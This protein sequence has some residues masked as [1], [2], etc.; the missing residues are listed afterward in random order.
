[1]QTI[2]LQVLRAIA[3]TTAEITEDKF[4]RGSLRTQDQPNKRISEVLVYYGIRQPLKPIDED[5]N[6]RSSLLT[7]DLEAAEE[8]NGIVNKTIKSRWIPFGG[9]QVAERLSNIL[10]GRFRDPPRKIQFDTWRF[11]ENVPTLGQGYQLGW[12]ENQDETG[13]PALAPIQI[14]RVQPQPE[15]FSYEAEEVL[16]TFRDG[17]GDLNDRVIVIPANINDVNL[18]TM[19]DSIFPE[20][21]DDDVS[22]SP[23]VTLTCIINDNVIVGS[24]N[25]AIPAFDVGDWPVGFTPTIVINGRIQGRGGRGGNGNPTFDG[26]INSDGQPGGPAL[27]TRNNIDVEYGA[28]AEV[29]SGAGGGGASDTWV[30]YSAYPAPGG[31]GGAGQL[32]GQGGDGNNGGT[33]GTNGTTEAG[34]PG[35]LNIVET[36]DGDVHVQAGAG[37]G[38]GLPGED[39][40]NLFGGEFGPPLPAG[41]A[42][43]AAIDGVSFVNVTSGSGDIRGGQIN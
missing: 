20:I 28:N 1:V 42:A 11:A 35:G 24:T 21:T 8:Y 3:T 41:G 17:A 26:S 37:G 43:G 7:P 34:G 23:A 33:P 18:R 36:D 5:D 9:Q 19:H 14:T 6:Y 13:L 40:W 2:R 4:L 30:F 39:G 38:P 25:T 12:T 10:L 15:K 29:W 27:F 16:F 22:A 32:P 31:G